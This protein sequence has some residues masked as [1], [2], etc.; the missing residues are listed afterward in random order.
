MSTERYRGRHLAFVETTEGWEF[1]TRTAASSAVVIVAITPR[2]VLL[3]EQYRPPVGARVIELPAGL[4]GDLGPEELATAARRELEEETGWT[5]AHFERLAGGPS[6]AGLTDEQVEFFRAEGLQRIGPGGGD[7]SEDIEVHVVP[8]ADVP[9]FVR[10]REAA[11]CLV[12]PKIWA[13]LFL[14]G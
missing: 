12:D 8:L 14:A 7:A 9:A 2:G 4:A 3:V 1:C 13:G 6:S 5:A 10:Q 11:G